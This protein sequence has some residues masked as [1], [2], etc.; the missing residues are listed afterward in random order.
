MRASLPFA[1]MHGCGNDYVVVDGV[2]ESIPEPAPLARRVCDRRTGVGSDGLILALPGD[3]APLRMRMFN[4]DG[5]EAEMCGNGLRCLAR[6]AHERA[7]VGGDRVVPV[8]TGAGTLT[9]EIHATAG[10]IHAVSVDMGRPHLER[11][12]IPMV[13]PAGHVVEELFELDDWRRPLTAVSMGNPH[14]VFFVDAVSDVPLEA[15]GPR[16]ERHAVF[17]RRTNVEIVEVLGPGEVRQRTWERGVG[18]T[19]ACGTG[20]CAVA[21]AGVLTGRTERRVLVRLLGGDLEIVWDEADHVHMRGPAVE[22]F[23]GSWPL[24]TQES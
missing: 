19:R 16:I 18:E 24:A 1:K 20:A 15:I 5:S 11:A 22:V 14:A 3:N 21:V 13:G 23:V 10:R 4:P 9:T 12:D 8:E 7:L 2:H 17:P 6:F